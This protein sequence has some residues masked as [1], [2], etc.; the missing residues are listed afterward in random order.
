MRCRGQ[1]IKPSFG[2]RVRDV[3]VT[4]NK[5]GSYTITFCPDQCG[6]LSF[7]VSI[8]GKPAPKCS[9]ERQVKWVISGIYGSGDITNG[10]N[11]MNSVG[12]GGQYCFAE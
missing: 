3:A 5:D 9:F 8:N 2:I 11:T 12:S 10:G 6:I 1:V 4:D 7:E